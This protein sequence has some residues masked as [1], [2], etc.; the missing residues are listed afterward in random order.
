MPLYEWECSCGHTESVWA[1]IAE[2]N[3]RPGHIC[4]GDFKRLP[5]GHGALY[6]EEGR[7][8][9][10][11]GLSDRPITSKAQHERLMKAAG[12]VEAGD[13]IPKRIRDNP[14]NPKMK[15]IVGKDSKGRWL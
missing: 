13:N 9:T 8:R 2:R 1:C 5:G 12:V 11:L 3:L 10:H 6:F 7:A 15:E 4:R 14:I